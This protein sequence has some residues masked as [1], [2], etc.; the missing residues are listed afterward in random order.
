MYTLYIVS[1]YKILTFISAIYNT[2]YHIYT[3]FMTG[4]SG[5]ILE[6]FCNKSEYI[7]I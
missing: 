1:F 4:F 7:K 5:E 2:V 6:V 3:E